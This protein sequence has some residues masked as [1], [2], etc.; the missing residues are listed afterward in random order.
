MDEMRGEIRQ[1]PGLSH[2]CVFPL[3]LSALF[4]VFVDPSA[5]ISLLT[6]RFYEKV[7]SLLASH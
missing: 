3:T 1:D 4:L 7:K 6:F 5:K 2:S